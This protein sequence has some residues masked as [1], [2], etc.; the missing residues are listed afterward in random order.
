MKSH[1]PAAEVRQAA[2][3]NREAGQR[4]RHEIHVARA[5][6][7]ELTSDSALALA[8]GV[9]YDTLMN[10]YSG[11]TMP[12]PFHVRKVA[13]I[14]QVPYSELLAAY[15]GTAPPDQPLH[16]A[17]AELVAEIRSVVETEKRASVQRDRMIADALRAVA[18][19]LSPVADAV[20]VMSREKVGNGHGR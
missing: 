13:T 9:H 11:K 1:E 14:L 7:T 3:P 4:I 20:P 2:L 16:V 8:A 18:A 6:N 10:W 19:V 12:R 17:V 15:E 5:R